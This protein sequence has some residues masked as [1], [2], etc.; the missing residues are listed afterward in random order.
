M[1]E[2]PVLSFDP[3]AVMKEQ[4]ESQLCKELWEL[5]EKVKQLECQNSRSG[6]DLA[7][8]CLVPDVVIPYKFKTPDFE[9]YDWSKC[10]EAH[11]TMYFSHMENYHGD[12]K[13][14]IHIFQQSLVG[15]ALKWYFNLKGRQ[16]ETFKV[17]TNAF[18]ENYKHMLEFAPTRNTVMSMG[19]RPRETI[20]EYDQRWKQ[21]AGRV[22]PP[23]S[24]KEYS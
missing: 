18:I 11:V 10:P 15:D 6:M 24:S 7:G 2:N 3:R 20:R 19:C 13:L 1:F 4:V 16:I 5:R 14:L 12:K 9:K 21:M 23:L 8:I 17:L 22:Q